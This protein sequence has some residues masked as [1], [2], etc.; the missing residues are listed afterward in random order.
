M[1]P[2]GTHRPQSSSFLGLPYRIL[3][4]NPK[5]E[6]LW[7]L[8][9]IDTYF[10]GEAAAAQRLPRRQRRWRWASGATAMAGKGVGM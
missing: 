4:M 3:N 5:N 1:E 8:W 10:E 2:M 9:V 6:L 7:S